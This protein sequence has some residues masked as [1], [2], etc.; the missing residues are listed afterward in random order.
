MSRS[1]S[2]LNGRGKSSNSTIGDSSPSIVTTKAPFRGLFSL[3]MTLK[4]ASLSIFSIFEARVLNTPHDL[5]CSIVAVRVCI[6]SSVVRMVTFTAGCEDSRD[7]SSFVEDL[8]FPVD[9][10]GGI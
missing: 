5:Q 4:P 10:E 3:I 1:R 6:A 8:R 2:F 7:S 9:F